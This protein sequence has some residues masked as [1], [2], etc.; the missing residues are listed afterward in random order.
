MVAVMVASAEPLI[1]ADP[2]TSPLKLIVRAV[3]HV[4][5]EPVVLALMVAGRLRVTAAPSTP[6][7]ETSISD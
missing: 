3:V 6:E 7:P 4:A 1:E 2:V 5:A